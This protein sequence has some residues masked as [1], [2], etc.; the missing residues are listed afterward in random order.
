VDGST[1]QYE[2]TRR[3][4]R[5]RVTDD[6]MPGRGNLAPGMRALNAWAAHALPMI[7]CQGGAD[8]PTQKQKRHPDWMALSF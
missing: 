8:R 4:R 5:P 2:S 3:L 1:L 7:E 6:R